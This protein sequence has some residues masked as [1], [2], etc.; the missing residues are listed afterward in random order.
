MFEDVEEVEENIRARK[1]VHMQA[2][3]EKFLVPKEEDCQHVSDSEQEDSDCDS[4]PEQQKGKKNAV[5]DDGELFSKERGGF[6]FASREAFT[7]EQPDFLKQPGFC[8]TIHDP[9]DIHMESYVSYFED[10][11]EHTTEP[12]PL[13]IEEKH[14][15]ESHYF[16]PTE[17]KGQSFPMFHVNDYYDFDPWEI[18][19]EEE[20]EPNV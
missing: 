3:L 14:C 16:V 19:E 1:G 13:Y 9:M 15:V 18:H 20:G 8:H 7:E 10:F 11:Q 4:E 12:F 5:F 2:Y 17:D 6:L